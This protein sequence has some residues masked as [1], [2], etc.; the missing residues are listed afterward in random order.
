MRA[1]FFYQ[2]KQL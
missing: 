2:V 1:F